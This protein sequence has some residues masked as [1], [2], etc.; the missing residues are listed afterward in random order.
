MSSIEKLLSQYLFRNKTVAYIR[1]ISVQNT[2]L[3]IRPTVLSFSF[4]CTYDN[5]T[6]IDITKYITYHYWQAKV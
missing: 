6:K 4:A 1:S 2:Q 5:D 3:A